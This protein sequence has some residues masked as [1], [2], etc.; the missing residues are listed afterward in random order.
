MSQ[1][2]FYSILSLHALIS[3]GERI[4]KV[5]HKRT[6]RKTKEKRNLAKLGDCLDE[7][8]T[9]MGRETTTTGE[10]TTTVTNR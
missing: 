4:E 7:S 6:K 2:L 1:H 10:T 3:I 5:W 8:P 9:V